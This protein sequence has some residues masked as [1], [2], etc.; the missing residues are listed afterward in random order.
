MN[1]H[2]QQKH[3]LERLNITQYYDRCQW[4]VSGK[5]DKDTIAYISH[6]PYS[7]KLWCGQTLANLANCLSIAKYN[8]PK[9][10]KLCTVICLVLILPKFNTLKFLWRLIRQ[11]LAPPKVSAIRY[12]YSECSILELSGVTFGSKLFLCGFYNATYINIMASNFIREAAIF[13]HYHI[14]MAIYWDTIHTCSLYGHSCSIPIVAQIS[15]EI[16]NIETLL[17]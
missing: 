3:S 16:W 1:L 12:N 7:A 17:P 13:F 6:V 10:S 8:P 5:L 14:S 15:G 11:S 4:W 9:F 2:S